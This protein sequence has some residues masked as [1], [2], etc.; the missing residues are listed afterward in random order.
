MPRLRYPFS[1]HDILPPEVRSQQAYTIDEAH[2][3]DAILRVVAYHRR[4]YDLAVV[5]HSRQLTD[6]VRLALSL[7]FPL[8]PVANFGAFDSLPLEILLA[9]SRLLDITSVLQLLQVNRRAREVVAVVPEYSFVTK[10]GLEAVLALC[11]VRLAS[12]FSLAD[13]DAALRTEKCPRCSELGGFIFLPTL[14][15]C[16]FSCLQEAPELQVL[17]ASRVGHK[18]HRRTNRNGSIPILRSISGVYTLPSCP[19]ERCAD[20]WRPATPL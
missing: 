17:S 10:H 14:Q 19:R 2:D 5:W 11:K 20:S 8:P 7:G 13:L 16:S 15:R 4:D 3:V 6:V 9:A 18:L 12:C 1:E